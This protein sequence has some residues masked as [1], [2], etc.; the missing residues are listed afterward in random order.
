MRRKGG[1]KAPSGGNRR[2]SMDSLTS[3]ISTTDLD[4]DYLNSVL[5]YAM[6]ASSGSANGPNE[7]NAD[8]RAYQIA[9]ERSNLM[10][11]ITSIGSG[12]EG[13]YWAMSPKAP[14]A[15][16]VPVSVARNMNSSLGKFDTEDTSHSE[17]LG[18]EDMGM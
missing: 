16:K 17:G 12:S 14:A 8:A 4:A 15:Q 9:V 7:G 2:E 18:Y 10:D 11:S 3:G 6:D 5:G 13:D 1:D